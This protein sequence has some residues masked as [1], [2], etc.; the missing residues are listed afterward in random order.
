[1]QRVAVESLTT[2][3]NVKAEVL[4]ESRGKRRQRRV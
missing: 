3:V 2:V 1:M 4:K